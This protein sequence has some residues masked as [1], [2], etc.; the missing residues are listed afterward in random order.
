MA[1]LPSPQSLTPQGGSGGVTKQAWT[2]PGDGWFV[3]VCPTGGDYYFDTR[4]PA[5]TDFRTTLSAYA[6]VN[7]PP[8]TSADFSAVT[9]LTTGSFGNGY[10]YEFGALIAFTA[11]AGTE[12]LVNVG[13]RD[14][15]QGKFS[16]EFGKFSAEKIGA[17][18]STTDLGEML[19][20]AGNLSVGDGSEQ[21]ATYAF[22]G[23]FVAPIE[24]YNYPFLF[25]S[26]FGS[27]SIN[28]PPGFY[29]LVRDHLGQNGGSGTGFIIYGEA[30]Q[31][32]AGSYLPTSAYSK[33]SV[34][35]HFFDASGGDG[36]NWGLYRALTD[37][38]SNS[39][40]DANGF[41]FI[42]YSSPLTIPYFDRGFYWE[43]IGN[44]DGATST[45]EWYVI[46]DTTTD[47]FYYPFCHSGGNVIFGWFFIVPYVAAQGDYTTYNLLKFNP[48][49]NTSMAVFSIQNNGYTNGTDRSG[50]FYYTVYV[51][52]TNASLSYPSGA[53][54]V[55]LLSVNGIA[56]RNSVT[57]GNNNS[58]SKRCNFSLGAGATDT[59][60]GWDFY[61]SNSDEL[62]GLFRFY[63]CAGN[64]VQD[65][66]MVIAEASASIAGTLPTGEVVCSVGVLAPSR[67]SFTVQNS[68]VVPI[69]NL[70]L[71]MQS[72]VKGAV[73]FAD[74]ANGTPCSG[75][76]SKT[77]FSKAIGYLEPYIGTNFAYSQVNVAF[78]MQRADPTLGVGPSG[79]PPSYNL[80]VKI[81]LA[82]KANQFQMPTLTQTAYLQ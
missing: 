58:P 33:G 19:C 17:C 59:S 9:L 69:A 54:S 37:V 80:D 23:G 35:F 82:D 48:G 1:F 31:N 76:F 27:E 26:N 32:F 28:L 66:L 71:Q 52:M 6:V 7:Y 57:S 50:G 22:A 42:N 25:P 70:I 65:V 68:G 21:N 45:G 56:T 75:P 34:V 20:K 15:S 77:L 64:F 72:V 39:I 81:D 61:S 8:R 79:G 55:E 51:S 3:W 18:G 5:G 47:C 14:G 63:D 53:F 43:K 38:P 29:I 49:A 62:E 2:G 24:W 4:H 13:S 16:L 11:T 30:T 44:A 60:Q 12:Y 73:Q 46:F 40:F 10:G 41:G 78:A 67:S 36:S 74:P